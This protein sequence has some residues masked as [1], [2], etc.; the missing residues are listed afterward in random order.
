MGFFLALHPKVNSVHHMFAE[1]FM[2]W[3]Y[4]ATLLSCACVLKFLLVVCFLCL[5]KNCVPWRMGHFFPAWYLV[6]EDEMRGA[7]QQQSDWEPICIYLADA[8]VSR[9]AVS[10]LFW[11]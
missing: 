7:T 8:Q 11:A 1:M 5:S 9:A 10:V 6:G 2:R 3:A 4:L